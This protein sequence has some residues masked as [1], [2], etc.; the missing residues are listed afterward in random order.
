MLLLVLV[1]FVVL[2]GHSIL[3]AVSEQAFGCTS[4]LMLVHYHKTGH[5]ASR[6]IAHALNQLLAIE[7]TESMSRPGAPVSTCHD[8]VAGALWQSCHG[9]RASPDLLCRPFPHR[10]RVVHFVRDPFD[11]I[12]S[13]FLYHRQ[14]P[15]PEPWILS[16]H[17]CSPKRRI[18]PVL[19]RFA[20]SIR[21]SYS[22]L[23]AVDGL[24]HR[25]LPPSTSFHQAL[26]SM[27]M[28]DAVRL[29]ATWMIVGQGDILRM[30][31]NSVSLAG[32]SPTAR[33]PRHLSL[34]LSDLNSAPNRTI[35]RLVSWLQSAPGS[36]RE[37]NL[38][39]ALTQ[40]FRKAYEHAASKTTK[41]HV[42]GDT[43]SREER[44][45]LVAAL[46][47]DLVLRPVLCTAVRALA[48]GS[49]SSTS[50]CHT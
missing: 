32:L 38:G 6:V 3:Q 31:A 40:R 16:R 42:T 44:A 23:A 34:Q 45:Q 18:L 29:V 8:L 19:V 14:N 10:L 28:S 2:L 13:A 30:A 7:F 1:P 5:D 25:L 43:V 47:A 36:M 49:G 21:I 9:I 35:G 33:S 11:M 50:A 12:V 24:C 48:N 22:Q 27:S 15:P 4:P 39:D 37:R 17:P 41:R 26:Q 46:E 20:A